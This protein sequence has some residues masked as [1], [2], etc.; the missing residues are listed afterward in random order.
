MFSPVQHV[1]IAH[2]DAYQRL[3]RGEVILPAVLRLPD[4]ENVPL[5]DNLKPQGTAKGR[6]PFQDAH[7]VQVERHPAI[8]ARIYKDWRPVSQ[9]KCPRH[10]AYRRIHEIESRRIHAHCGQ[11]E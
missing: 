10:L 8:D 11:K 3:L 4:V 6:K 9:R 2:G 5:L 7:A 1:L